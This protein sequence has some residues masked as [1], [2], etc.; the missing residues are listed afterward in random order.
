MPS[1]AVKQRVR[2]ASQREAMLSGARPGHHH[3]EGGQEARYEAE[4]RFS[5]LAGQ[6]TTQ[7]VISS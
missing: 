3:T 5:G 7:L 2:P 1:D 4:L 6:F